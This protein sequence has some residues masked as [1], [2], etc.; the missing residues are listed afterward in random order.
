MQ[1]DLIQDRKKELEQGKKGSNPSE[2]YG[3]F[4]YY[5]LE[6]SPPHSGQV[7]VPAWVTKPQFGQATGWEGPIGAPQATQCGSPTGFRT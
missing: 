1:L 4:N 3:Q 6:S 7:M 2:R 5:L